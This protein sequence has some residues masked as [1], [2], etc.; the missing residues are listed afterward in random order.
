MGPTAP[1]D[2]GLGG[3]GRLHVAWSN[4]KPLSERG[5][6]ER[7]SGLM[8]ASVSAETR[9]WAVLRSP[10][11][12]SSVLGGLCQGDRR[13]RPTHTHWHVQGLVRGWVRSSSSWQRSHG[14]RWVVLEKTH[15]D[16][17]QQAGA[18]SG[19]RIGH[20]QDGVGV[21][22]RFTHPTTG[23]RAPGSHPNGQP[24]RSERGDAGG[25]VAGDHFH[26]IGGLGSA[27]GV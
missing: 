19:R 23:G 8:L 11:S 21:L 27:V 26:A 24:R 18:D 5:L 17:T 22:V 25:Q 16:P 12:R 1:D 4:R 6:C 20:R 14:S 3:R 15:F 7:T 9:R 13:D 10:R 2:G